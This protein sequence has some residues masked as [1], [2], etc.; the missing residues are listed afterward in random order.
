MAPQGEIPVAA[1]VLGVCGSLLFNIQNVGL[2][3]TSADYRDSAMVYSVNTS[4]MDELA[5]Q[6]YR[7]LPRSDDVFVGDMCVY[8]V[9]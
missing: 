7:R 9:R 5:E 6:E 8:L 3:A 1:S 4:S 2:I